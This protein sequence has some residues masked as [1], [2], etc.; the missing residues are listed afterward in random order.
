MLV[1]VCCLL[2]DYAVVCRVLLVVWHDLL[3][4][5]V[6][7]M[8]MLLVFADR[9]RCCCRLFAVLLFVVGCCW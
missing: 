8:L 5:V 3:F 6:C 7:S 4:V 1:G 2:F 9:S